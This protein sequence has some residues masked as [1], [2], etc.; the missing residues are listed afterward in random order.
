MVR[1]GLFV[2]DPP[3]LLGSRCRACESYTFPATTRCPYCYCSQ[4]EVVS[5][6]N[7]GRIYSFTISRIPAPGYVGPVPYGLGLVELEVGIRVTSL[8]IADPI[9]QLAVDA[10]VRLTLLNVGTADEPA[11]SYAY[12]VV[13]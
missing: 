7:V 6:P 10:P 5:L 8:L 11:L 2:K 12:E 3:T 1:E 9:E 4:P 13:P